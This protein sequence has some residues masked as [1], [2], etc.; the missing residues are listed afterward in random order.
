MVGL[1]RWILDKCDGFLAIFMWNF[2]PRLGRTRGIAQM[3]TLQNALHAVD[4]SSTAETTLP[5]SKSTRQM[6]Y[7]RLSRP[8]FHQYSLGNMI[9]QCSPSQQ[10]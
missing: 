1:F 10:A 9:T 5:I 7:R 8:D 3:L 2:S 4:F 6:P